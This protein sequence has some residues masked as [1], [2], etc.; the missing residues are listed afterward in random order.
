MH[1]VCVLYPLGA[2][3]AIQ[4]NFQDIASFVNATPTRAPLAPAWKLELGP[5][6]RLGKGV[7]PRKMDTNR[8]ERAIDK[9]MEDEEVY[10]NIYAEEMEYIRHLIRQAGLYGVEVLT[11]DWSVWLLSEFACFF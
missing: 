2:G 11:A 7:R 1:V 6:P 4:M 3:G 10:R 5:N 9:L 8:M